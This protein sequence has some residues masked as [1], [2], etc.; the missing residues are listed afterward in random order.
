MEI[1]GI[2]SLSQQTTDNNKCGNCVEDNHDSI[3]IEKDFLHQKEPSKSTKK[4]QDK[5]VKKKDENLE[6]DPYNLDI[7]IMDL[8]SMTLPSDTGYQS[9]W[10]R[11]S[12]RCQTQRGYTCGNCDTQQ[13]A[14]TCIRC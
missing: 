11:C 8:A 7:Q 1:K 10:S 5:V 14:Y 12:C 3:R 6:E 4:I 13:Q 2:N 9:C